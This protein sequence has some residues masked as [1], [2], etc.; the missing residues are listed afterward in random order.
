MVNGPAALDELAS[1]PRLSSHHRRAAASCTPAR[2]GRPSSE[3]IDEYRRAAHR[4]TNTPER[5]Y[6][7]QHAAR[8]SESLARST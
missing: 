6:L 7:L 3:A 4:T 1:D 2:A 8:L 5:D